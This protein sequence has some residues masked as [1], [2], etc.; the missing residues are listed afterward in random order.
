MSNDAESTKSELE[1]Q[2][3]L[4]RKEAKGLQVRWTPQRQAIVEHFLR[5]K[6]HITV[7]DLHEVV[8]AD[9]AGISAAT[10]YRTLNL[11]VDIDVAVK[12][13]FNDGPAVF[14]SN[15]DRHHHDHLIDADTGEIHEFENDEIEALQ[16]LVAEKLGYE[17]TDHRLVLYGKKIS[18]K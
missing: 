6:G 14:E 8:K 5:K 12:R 16:K 4:I 2:I 3:E 17:L 10:V 7:E 18:S 1:E 15:L 13:V 9:D 11:L